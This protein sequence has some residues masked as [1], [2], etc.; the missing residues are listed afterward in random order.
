MR[1]F[2][3]SFKRTVPKDVYG[4]KSKSLH[5][6][7]SEMWVSMMFEWLILYVTGLC[8]N[9]KIATLGPNVFKKIVCIIVIEKRVYSFGL[10]RLY[11]S[12][13]FGKPNTHSNY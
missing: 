8:F 10:F 13:K 5:T 4:L 2:K 1:T 7:I 3:S 6:H 11:K 9:A 12:Y